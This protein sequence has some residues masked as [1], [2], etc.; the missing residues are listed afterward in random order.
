MILLFQYLETVILEMFWEP[1]FLMKVLMKIQLFWS[2]RLSADALNKVSKKKHI[3]PKSLLVSEPGMLNFSYP[4][5]SSKMKQLQKCRYLMLLTVHKMVLVA[6]THPDEHLRKGSSRVLRYVDGR[7]DPVSFLTTQPAGRGA[8]LVST[9]EHDYSG[10]G[11]V[12][13]VGSWVI[14]SFISNL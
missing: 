3:V 2:L 7:N 8:S 12:I 4:S 9:W 14:T 6:V 1:Q 13:V 5:Q 11:V 10:I